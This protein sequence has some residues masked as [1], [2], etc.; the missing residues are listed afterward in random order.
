[1]KNATYVLLCFLCFLCTCVRAQ[2]TIRGFV[3]TDDGTPLP[4]ATVY[5]EGTTTGTVTDIDGY[6]EIRLPANSTTLS[7]SHTG[8]SS[9]RH[10]VTDTSYGGWLEVDLTAGS[11]LP[12]IIV[13]GGGFTSAE[14]CCVNVCRTPSC[15]FPPINVGQATDLAR[16]S[17]Y[18]NPFHTTI[19]LRTDLWSANQLTVQLMNSLGQVVRNWATQP[20]DIGEQHLIFTVPENLPAGP[21]YLRLSDGHGRE[22]TKVIVKGET[23]RR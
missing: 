11:N 17:V 3:L 21:Y 23:A 19:N 22:V 13:Y 9:S 5:A 10:L 12:A 18:P 4:Y 20:V 2:E 16:S 6:Y 8:Y 14:K 7:F 1:M 15:T